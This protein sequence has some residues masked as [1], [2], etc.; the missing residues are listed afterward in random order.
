MLNLAKMLVQHEDIWA[1][2][3]LSICIWQ[4]LLSKETYSAFNVDILYLYVWSLG[5]DPITIALLTY[6]RPNELQEHMQF[7]Q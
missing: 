5:I 1:T 4:M 7:G 2:V 3:Y 6:A